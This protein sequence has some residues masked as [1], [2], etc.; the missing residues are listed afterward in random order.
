[1]DFTLKLYV[2]TERPKTI[3]VLYVLGMLSIA[4][5]GL[6]FLVALFG[7]DFFA[8]LLCL[9]SGLL[10]GSVLIALSLIVNYLYC[11]VMKEY[12]DAQPMKEEE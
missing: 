11:L 5:G 2:D 7:H 12:F 1:M 9:L 8:A 10:S 3:I 6:M 4:A